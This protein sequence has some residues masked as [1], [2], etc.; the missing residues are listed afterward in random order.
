MPFYV[1]PETDAVAS[2]RLDALDEVA[3]TLWS[4]LFKSDGAATAPYAKEAADSTGG[5]LDWGRWI[6]TPR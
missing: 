4:T 3:P 2:V 1:Q 5:A 6:S